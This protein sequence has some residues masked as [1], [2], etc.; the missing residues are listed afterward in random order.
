VKEHVRNIDL[1]MLVMHTINMVN[2]VNRPNTKLKPILVSEETY[3]R[4]KKLG[5]A[6]DSFNDVITELLNE[7]G[8]LKSESR[9]PTQDQIPVPAVVKHQAGDTYE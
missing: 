6:G 8:V 1:Y 4:L 3:L 7:K 2:L 5:Y 9:V